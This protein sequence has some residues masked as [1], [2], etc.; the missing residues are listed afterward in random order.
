[1][2]TIQTPVPFLAEREYILRTL[3]HHY[4]GLDIEIQPRQGLL[5]TEVCRDHK[6]LR[7]RDHFWMQTI[8]G[9]TYIKPDRLPASVYESRESGLDHIIILYGQDR[10]DVS[11]DVID[12][13]VD[14]LAG[15]FFM[16][17]RWEESMHHVT[18]DQHGRFPG[19][20]AAVFAA[21]FGNR[22]IVDEYVR[23]LRKW[24]QQIGVLVPEQKSHPLIAA[25]CDV[26]MPSYWL[27]QPLY[28]VWWREWNKTKSLSSITSSLQHRKAVS[29]G[30]ETDPHDTFDYMMDVVERENLRMHF[31]FIAGGI[32]RFEGLYNIDDAYILRL[33]ERIRRR[34]HTIGLH[35][36]YNSFADAGLL[37]EEK[38]K[39]DKANQEPVHASRQHYLKFA[40]PRTWQ[41]LEEVGIK[42]DSSMGY[43]DQIGFRCGTCKPFP[44]FD[45]HQRKTLRIMERPLLIMDVTLRYYMKCS[46][47]E[48]IT[49]SIAIKEQV[50]QHGG[51]F[52]FIWHNS[53]LGDIDGWGD[54]REVYESLVQ[55]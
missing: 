19:S 45:V 53:N 43:P 34:G 18:E 15:A 12:C 26:D 54:W 49:K 44:V 3:F 39:L 10:L 51:E 55:S 41:I 24:L 7:L 30:A 38:K 27:R 52:V 47:H 36:S 50:R 31:Y 23:I 6:I 16:L 33:L 9:E 42:S 5:H 22:P 21:G 17:T 4:I 1:M 2:I 48:A 40:V 29:I 11:D 32:S 14:L 25:S 46:P 35:P 8:V 20:A 28:K 13:H 37:G